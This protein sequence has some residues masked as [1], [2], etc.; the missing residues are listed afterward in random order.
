MFSKK[1]KSEDIVSV[2][3]N[4]N[5]EKNNE[6]KEEN[7]K[8]EKS[9]KEKKQKVKEEKP[10][11]EKSK[12]L[13]HFKRLPDNGEINTYKWLKIVQSIILIALGL[14]LTIISVYNDP[15]NGDSAALAL[16]YSVG[17]ILTV[18]GIINILAG[19]LLFR[20]PFSSEIPTGVITICFAVVV[21]F[22]PNLIDT[23][24][25]YVIMTALFSYFA[26]LVIYGLD[27]IIW[28][29]EKNKF[30]GIVS[31]IESGMLLVL[32][33]IYIV[34]WNID[35]TKASIE[36]CISIIVGI[37]L[38]L[39]GIFSLISTVRKVKNTKEALKEQ[40]EMKIIDEENKKEKVEEKK[41]EYTVS[42]LEDSDKK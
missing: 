1:K 36:K 6:L 21:F 27:M 13:T 2:E 7:I 26:I 22:K 37:I 28:R 19:Y 41:I 8:K 33:I 32:A 18:Y 12:K 34:L 35:K 10:K 16:G 4:E 5:K 31:F 40:E 15:K 14:I 23:I 9:K 39:V 29:E 42:Q 30:K 24:L 17:S 11:K 25:P 38:I 20:S 3:Q